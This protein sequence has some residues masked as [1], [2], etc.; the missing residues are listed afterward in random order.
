MEAALSWLGDDAH[1]VSAERVDANLHSAPP[2]LQSSEH[3]EKAYKIGRDMLVF[4][5]KRMIF[6]DVQGWTGKK[7]EYMSY[8]LRYCTAFALQSAG[9]IAFFLSAH[10]AVYA[11]IPGASRLQQDLSK[12]RTDIWDVHA[13]LAK[14][15][16]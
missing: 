7:I 5:T 13:H 8:P 15:L 9:M 2:L 10:V 14:K 1:E 11:D 16:L 12:G 3:V 6:I 4:T